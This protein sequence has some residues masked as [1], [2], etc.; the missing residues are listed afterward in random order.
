MFQTR[1]FIFRKTVVFYIQSSTHKTL[2]TDACKTY[3]T[4][5][6][7]TTVFLKLNPRISNV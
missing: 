6:V 4:I 5:T 3:H 7:Y 2:Y 1:G